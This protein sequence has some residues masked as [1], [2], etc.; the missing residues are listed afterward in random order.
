[1]SS[2]QKVFS[3]DDLRKEILS[4]IPKRCKSCHNKLTIPNTAFSTQIGHVTQVHHYV[5]TIVLQQRTEIT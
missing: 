1:M 3:T 4:Y 2:I 5:I